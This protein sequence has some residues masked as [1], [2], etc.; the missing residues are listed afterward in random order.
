LL[1]LL[2]VEVEVP[3]LSLHGIAPPTG[4]ETWLR[5]RIGPAEVEIW[6]EHGHYPHLVDPQRFLQRVRSFDRP[7]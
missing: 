2:S 3:F 4:Y 6:D 7:R 1:S 5:D